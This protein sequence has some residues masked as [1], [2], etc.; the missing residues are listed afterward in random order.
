MQ[1]YNQPAIEGHLRS[2]RAAIKRRIQA[3]VKQP[4]NIVQA[5]IN[6]YSTATKQRPNS[7]QAA[8]QHHST[9]I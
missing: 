1:Q 2:K 7:H 3:A 9:S 8:A 6:I 4:P 5:S